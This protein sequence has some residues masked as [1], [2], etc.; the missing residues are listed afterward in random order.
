MFDI[1]VIGAGV[2]G[3]W[4]ALHLAKQGFKTALLDQ[5]PLPHTRGSSHGQS[6]GIRKAYPEPHLTRMMN[7]AYEQW[8]ELERVNHETL[9]I[10]TGLLTLGE[11]YEGYFGKV[12]DSFEEN[13]GSKYELYNPKEMAVRFPMIDMGP[14]IW[15]CY[16]PSAGILMADKCLK[17]LWNNFQKNGGSLI[18][19]SQIKEIV[20]E[21]P[22]SI[23]LILQNENVLKAKSIVVCAGPWT[24]RLLEPLGWKI[25]LKPIKIS[26]FY[27]KS[28]GHIPHN[29]YFEDESIKIWGMAQHEYNGLNKIALD[30]GPE[31]NP[32]QRDSVDIS[33]EKETLRKFISKKFLKVDPEPSIEES[34]IY[35]VSPDFNH[36]LDRHPKYP[37]IV[38]GCGFSG[39]GFKMGPVTGEILANMVTGRKSKYDT[40]PFKASRFDIQQFKAS[41]LNQTSSL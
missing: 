1:V 3:S 17:L 37:N 41:R 24:S 38:V 8:H 39:M 6:R 30:T 20:P 4:T 27:F 32:D 15:G 18:D 7:D 5:F 29:F 14:K 23:K 16:D 36:I 31:C 22:E 9:F 25:P 28:T 12:V 40:Q 35:T 10:P 26:V 11:R 21:G 19:N 2:N 13:T 33:K 34:C